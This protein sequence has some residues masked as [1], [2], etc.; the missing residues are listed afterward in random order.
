MKVVVIEPGLMYRIPDKL[1]NELTE[2]ASEYDRHQ[3]HLSA[4][5][6]ER[7][8]D[9]YTAVIKKVQEY[10]PTKVDGIYCAN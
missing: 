8:H 4:P 10:K 3:T 9:R 7:A 5:G 1:Y 2:I 6:A